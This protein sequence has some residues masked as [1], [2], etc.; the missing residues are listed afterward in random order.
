MK[1]F[2][3]PYST[4]QLYTFLVFALI[5]S[6]FTGWLLWQ[7]S[8][9]DFR[10]NHNWTAT[11]LAVSGPFTGA[12]ARPTEADCWRMSE[13]LFWFGLPGV[14]VALGVPWLPW[15]WLRRYWV[16]PWVIW[17]VGWLIWFLSGFVSLVYALD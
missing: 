14:I 11:L 2:K 3:I 7:Q 13:R 12:L 1:S 17:V 5:F 15:A 9:A 16:L 4:A 8:P 6:A 10:D